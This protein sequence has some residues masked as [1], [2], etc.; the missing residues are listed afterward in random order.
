MHKQMDSP[1]QKP[2]VNDEGELSSSVNKIL[3][4]SPDFAKMNKDVLKSETDKLVGDNKL[5]AVT[6]D[7]GTIVSEVDKL[8]KMDTTGNGT[9]ESESGLR[10]A[11]P[12][13]LP[14]DVASKL[15]NLRNSP[16]LDGEMNPVEKK[17]IDSEDRTGTMKQVE[18]RK[19]ANGEIELCGGI[20]P[21][22]PETGGKKEKGNKLSGT[23]D[24]ANAGA[25]QEKPVRPDIINRPFIPPVLKDPSNLENK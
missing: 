21:K 8:N 20:V 15:G 13:E 16:P 17:N 10:P 25:Q 19:G 12:G 22:P 23:N 11:N 1:P 6:V 18:T 14:P 4:D 9:G 7:P 3:R 5:P 24:G 2:T